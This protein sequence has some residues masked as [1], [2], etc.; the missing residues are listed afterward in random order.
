M[1]YIRFS[2]LLMILQVNGYMSASLDW[3]AGEQI[4]AGASIGVTAAV[5]IAP[6]P[7]AG[8]AI[9]TWADRN[10]SL[11]YYSI[12]DNGTWTTGAINIGGSH[13]VS[14][15]IYTAMGPDS[16]EVMAAWSSN[17]QVPYYSIY[18][19]SSWTTDIIPLN[20]SYGSLLD[21]VLAVGPHSGEIAAAW[22]DNSEFAPVYYSIYSGGTWTTNTIPLG[23]SDGAYQN[24]FISQGATSGTLMA[25]WSDR[26]T[27]VPYYSIYSSGAWAVADTI[28]LGSSTIVY[29][30]VCVTQG[31]N[32]GE[33]VAAWADANDYQPYYSIYQAG[34]WTTGIIPLGT[35]G[36]VSGNVFI[37]Q[38]PVPGDLVATWKD[39]N[40]HGPYY[41]LYSNGSWSDGAQIP[42]GTSTGSSND[43]YVGLLLDGYTV[44]AT[45]GDLTSHHVP[46]FATLIGSP[47]PDAVTSLDGAQKINS[48]GTVSELYNQLNWLAPAPGVLPVLGYYVYRDGS[49]IG[50][51]PPTQLSYQDHNRQPGVTYVY[52]VTAFNASGEGSQT[53]ITL[54]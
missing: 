37:T 22:A 21:V 27:Q 47:T 49:L 26:I 25:T 52:G 6:G 5:T 40:S 16:T 1:N 53:T 20:G 17:H 23:T 44:V 51:L 24:V 33:M 34:V 9:A 43:V 11:P 19:G 30:D 38:G 10:S 12:Y 39:S 29:I 15:N 7:N 8:N 42:L 54:P 46:Y 45:W 32:S 35:S 36:G 41:S 13:S 31:P 48:F 50:T 3:N 18:N 4:P 14:N 2:A 28:P